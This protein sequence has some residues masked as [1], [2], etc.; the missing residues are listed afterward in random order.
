MAPPFQEANPKG[1]GTLVFFGLTDGAKLNLFHR[2]LG[3]GKKK[4]Q[5]PTRGG[6]RSYFRF[7]AG[8][9]IEALSSSRGTGMKKIQWPIRP[10]ETTV[11]AEA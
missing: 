3:N 11:P 10:S 1:W 8:C 5:W 7:A 9:E 4:I 2:P 6:P